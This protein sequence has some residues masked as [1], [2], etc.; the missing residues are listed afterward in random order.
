MWDR[1]DLQDGW[2]VRRGDH[3]PPN[4]YIRNASIC[5]TTPT[6]HLLN[7]DRRPQTSQK[8]RNSSRTWIGHK[9]KEKTEKKA[10]RL[11]VL[12]QTLEGFALSLAS[13]FVSLSNS[14]VCQALALL[15]C[16]RVVTKDTEGS[17]VNYFCHWPFHRE[18]AGRGRRR[19]RHRGEPELN[20]NVLAW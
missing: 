18:V 2:G 11:W 14:G 16:H 8:A 7:A 20:H 9:K 3:L 10:G 6:E 17:P 15:T 4:K 13:L 12:T 5:G 1:R 19:Q